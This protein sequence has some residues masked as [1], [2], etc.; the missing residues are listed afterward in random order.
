M[1]A[2]LTLGNW[3]ARLKRG[4]TRRHRRLQAGARP[5]A[6]RR[7]RA[8]Q[9]GRSCY[10]ARGKQQDALDALEVFRTAL[11]VNP[12]NP[13][14]WYQLATL[15][16]DTSRLDG[17]GVGASRTRWPPTRRWAAAYNGLGVDRLQARRPRA[18]GD[19]RAQGARARARPAHRALQ[20]RPHP[21]GARRRRRRRRRST[22]RSSRPTR[23]TGRARFNLAQLRRARGD[24][25]GYLAELR[26]VRREGAR[27]RRLLLVP[28]PRG[29]GGGPSRRRGRPGPARPGGA[30]RL[31]GR[32][33]RPLRARR[34]LQS[35]GRRRPRR[36]KKSARPSASRRRCA[37]TRRRASDRH[38]RWRIRWTN[39]VEPRWSTMEPMRHRCARAA[40]STS[41]RG[42]AKRRRA[43]GGLGGEFT[44]IA[45]E[46]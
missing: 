23:T 34:R 22:A 5:Q 21:R 44:P 39:G 9:P 31:R 26:D 40:D 14:S 20:P 41:E 37:R 3:L 7:H 16:L 30:A 46:A 29:A 25:D 45:D 17:G 43:T 6:R 4:P 10:L 11:R 18:G 19:A 33:A 32:A 27:L 35:P 13:Q 36:A 2:H 42:A 38:V 24:R 28:R 12:K 8:R 1:D 15:Y